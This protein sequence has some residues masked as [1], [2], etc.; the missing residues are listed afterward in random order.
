MYRRQPG[1]GIVHFEKSPGK[2][3]SQDDID[4]AAHGHVESQR[5]VLG[6]VG[7][8]HGEVRKPSVS[9]VP[10]IKQVVFFLQVDNFVRNPLS[11]E[12]H[13]GKR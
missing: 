5:L 10:G 6:R 9:V 7:A 3:A 1:V 11:A 4:A 13:L 12:E 2:G 8:P